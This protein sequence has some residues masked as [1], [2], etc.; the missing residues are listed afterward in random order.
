MLDIIFL[1]YNE[2]NAEENWQELK[3]KFPW[4]KRVHGIK[5][6]MNAHIECARKALTKN[7]YVVDGDNKIKEGWYFDYKPPYGKEEFVH[8]WRC[9]NPVNGLIYGY[10][11]VKLFNKK[12]L[13]S[14]KDMNV[15]FTMSTNKGFVKMEECISETH[16]NTSPF[17][18]WKSSFR[19]CAKLANE[20][21]D[22]HNNNLK[23]NKERLETWCNYVK[24][25]IEF[26]DY[27]LDGARRGREFGYNSGKNSN[28]LNL[29]N[30]FDYLQELF[31]DI[32]G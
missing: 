13:L 27:I 4:S 9:E 8:V 17:E 29:I 26:K 3:E 22:K 24:D 14:I 7:F 6:I 23:E 30:D 21:N 20:F 32:W 1:T 5:G 31:N 19:E 12:Q 11:G 2:T 28:K 16:F 15:D 10:S 25:N 18:S